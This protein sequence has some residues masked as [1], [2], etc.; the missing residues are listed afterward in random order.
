MRQLL[1]LI[2]AV[3]A[4]T[5]CE[6]IDSSE[7]ATAEIEAHVRVVADGHGAEITAR[8]ELQGHHLTFVEL[9]NGDALSANIDGHVSRLDAAPALSDYLEYQ[10]RLP[11][12]WGPV[13]V[14][15]HRPHWPGATLT[16]TLPEPFDL[17]RLPG[18][19]W[20]AED[21]VP[22]RWSHPAYGDIQL[23]I[24][25]GCIADFERTIADDGQ[26]DP[27]DLWPHSSWDGD[28]C[29]LEVRLE[30]RD[31]GNVDR[32]LASGSIEAVQLRE[33]TLRVWR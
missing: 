3:A 33:T 27:G 32:A 10:A 12:D 20:L 5:A 31:I 7:V 4:L 6:R 2:T 25:G 17:Y 28:T 13:E 18:E 9:S 30:R 1:T 15:L 11:A 14:R 16:A 23:H 8:L 24:T 29:R 26:I 21:I 19:Y 22:I